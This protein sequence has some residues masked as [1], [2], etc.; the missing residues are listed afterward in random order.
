[1][2]M[3]TDQSTD[4][5]AGQFL[6]EVRD[7]V[8]YLDA[9]GDKDGSLQWF[10][11]RPSRRHFTVRQLAAILERYVKIEEGAARARNEL[12]GTLLG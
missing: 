5:L 11:S 7:T 4:I 1:M 12:S 2:T 9:V 3:I 6:K 10:T 8:A